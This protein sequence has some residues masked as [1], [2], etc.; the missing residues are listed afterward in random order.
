MRSVKGCAR[1]DRLY[2][3]SVRKDLNVFNIQDRIEENKE[4]WIAH[5]NRMPGCLWQY[6]PVG[7]GI[8]RKRWSSDG[9]KVTGILLGPEQVIR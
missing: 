6:N 8:P 4:R 5:L 7:Q 9:Q 1:R 3:E 2:N